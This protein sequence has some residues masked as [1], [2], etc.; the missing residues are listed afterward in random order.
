M[1]Q[2]SHWTQTSCICKRIAE[3][4]LHS[5]GDIQ[6]RLAT[7]QVV[8]KDNLKP[9]WVEAISMDLGASDQSQEN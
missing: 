8:V 4:G 3:N 2:C 7:W 6:K 5:T 9:W 1:I